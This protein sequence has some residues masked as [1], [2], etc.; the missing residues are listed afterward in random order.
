MSDSA[1][2]PPGAS[3][4]AR[5]TA[6]RPSSHLAVLKDTRQLHTLVFFATTSPG[7]CW[8]RASGLK[9]TQERGPAC[10]LI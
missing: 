1:P 10:G 5:G 6:C 9:M 3:G 7:T 8:P 2:G 4:S